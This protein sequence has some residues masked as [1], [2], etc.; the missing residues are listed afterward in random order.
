MNCL[1]L[2]GLWV[3]AR[4]GIG[5]AYALFDCTHPPE[6]IEV[7]LPDV[8]D[9]A[10]LGLELHL[11]NG[12]TRTVRSEFHLE[13]RKE[14]AVDENDLRQQLAKLANSNFNYTLLGLLPRATNRETATQM[15][16]FMRMMTVSPLYEPDEQIRMEI[17]YHD[18]KEWQQF[19]E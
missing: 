14:V 5:K 8:Q 11:C 15:K 19:R 7:T 9:E 4:Y 6:H 3:P 17:V 10:Q 16:D 2:E 12:V 1:T 13:L 18:G